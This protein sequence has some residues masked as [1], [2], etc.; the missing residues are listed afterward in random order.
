MSFFLAFDHALHQLVPHHEN[1]A[2]LEQLIECMDLTLLD[3]SATAAQLEHLSTQ[4]RQ[5]SIA[6]ICVYPEHL[7]FFNPLAYNLAT[8]VNFPDGTD[9][10]KSICDEIEKAILHGA[11]EIDY[12]FPYRKYL[13]G[14]H[15]EALAQAQEIFNFCH[16]KELLTKIIIETG[17]FTDITLLYHLAQQLITMGWHFLKT[18]TGK[19]SQ[20]ASLTA[21]TCLLAAIYESKISCGLKVSG[22]IRTITQAKE[23]LALA[24][25]IL[26]KKACKTWFRLGASS[27]ISKITV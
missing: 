1:E 12:V 2:V 3:K 8:V 19:I 25:K 7:S 24:E 21:V 26:G 5:Y 10:V 20:G 9:D 16:Q 22:G 14:E 11:S 27:L 18:S 13:K 4:A 17:A 15:V 23:Y 6:A